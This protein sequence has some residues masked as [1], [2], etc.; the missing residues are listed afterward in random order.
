MKNQRQKVI[1]N[2]QNEVECK[3]SEDPEISSVFSN[4]RLKNADVAKEQKRRSV[5]VWKIRVYF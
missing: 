3:P 5:T 2:N 1:E 4:Q